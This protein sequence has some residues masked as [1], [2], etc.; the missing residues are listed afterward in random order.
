VRSFLIN[1]TLTNEHGTI[2]TRTV[3]LAL[4]RSIASGIHED[5]DIVNHGAKPVC[6]DIEIAIRCGFADLLELKSER[7]ARDERPIKSV[8]LSRKPGTSRSSCR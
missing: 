1:R 6:F 2:P 5:I 7:I 4:S 8:F 3:G